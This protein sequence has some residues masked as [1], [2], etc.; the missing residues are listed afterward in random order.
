MRRAQRSKY[1]VLN[2]PLA[3][4]DA[5]KALLPGIKSPTVTPLAEAGWVSVQSVV[6]EDQFWHIAGELQAI[7]AE[8][9][10]VLAIEKRVG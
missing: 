6:E 8:G 7:G 3:A 5:V 2:A 10:L 1:I 9:I 4:L